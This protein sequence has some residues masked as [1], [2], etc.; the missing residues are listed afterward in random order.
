M[1]EH[2][3]GW[4]VIATLALSFSAELHVGVKEIAAYQV[5]GN[6]NMMWARLPDC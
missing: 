4:A 2:A 5:P 1:M 3:L 6:N